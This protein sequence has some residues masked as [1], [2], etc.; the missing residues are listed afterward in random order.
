MHFSNAFLYIFLEITNLNLNI[1][2]LFSRFFFTIWNRWRLFYCN[3]YI[4]FLTM[5]IKTLKN[6]KMSQMSCN[7]INIS[8]MVKHSSYQRMKRSEIRAFTTECFL[9]FNSLVSN[10]DFF[11]SRSIY[12]FNTL[13]TGG[14]CDHIYTLMWYPKNI[15]RMF[16][17]WVCNML[18]F[19]H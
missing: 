8:S 17:S 9:S 2:T 11:T 16:K 19:L 15:L 14:C 13:E 18:W 10:I 12:T 5:R 3:S 6:L 1:C 7:T 4:K